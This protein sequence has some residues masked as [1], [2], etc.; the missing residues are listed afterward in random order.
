MP[1]KS[2]KKNVGYNI[3]ELMM[4]NKKKGKERGAGGKPRSRAQILAIAL[5][6]AGVSKKKMGM[7]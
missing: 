4:D 6:K 5:S 2:G 1:L 7:K 3:H